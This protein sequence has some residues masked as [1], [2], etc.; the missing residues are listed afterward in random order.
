MVG[1]GVERGT[2]TS[3]IALFPRDELGPL[4]LK[5]GVAFG[6]YMTHLAIWKDEI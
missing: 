2:R 6:D 3:A 5:T 1:H 4:A